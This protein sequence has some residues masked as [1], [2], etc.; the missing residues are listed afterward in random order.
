MAKADRSTIYIY[1]HQPGSRHPRRAEGR[2]RPE[3]DKDLSD[4]DG[5]AVDV[6]TPPAW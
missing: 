3:G 5:I 4:H 2:R 6:Y 1:V